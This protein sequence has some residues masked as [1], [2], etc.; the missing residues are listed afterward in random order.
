[1]KKNN[2]KP[3]INLAD[4]DTVLFDLDG[5]L[6]TGSQPDKGT[7]M[8]HIYKPLK[9]LVLAQFKNEHIKNLQKRI[10]K[11]SFDKKKFVNDAEPL[12]N[13]LFFEEDA[14]DYHTALVTNTPAHLMDI[15]ERNFDFSF[16]FDEIITGDMVKNQKPDPAGYNLAMEK[17][18]ADKRYTIGFE[19]SPEGLLALK[20]A[21]VKTRVHVKNPTYAAQHADMSALATHTISSFHEVYSK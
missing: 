21:G 5:T 10:V 1:M 19:D 13:E 7:I 16:F 9:T 18:F 17:L 8:S 12:M 20:N 3:G 6:I 4:Y 2:I 15:H 11:S 14:H